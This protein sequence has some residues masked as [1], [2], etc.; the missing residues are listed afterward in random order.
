MIDG[1][2]ESEVCFRDRLGPLISCPGHRSEDDVTFWKLFFN[3]LQERYRAEYLSDAGGMN[4]YR[5]FKRKAWKKTHPLNQFLSKSVLKD[6]TNE[7]IWSGDDQ[8]EC[9]DNI[10]E[11]V[12]H[13][14][15]KSQW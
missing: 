15:Y 5:F 13:I 1:E 6:S 14:I 12:D 3:Y 4:P 9:K 8:N 11:E 2:E 7:E 10:V